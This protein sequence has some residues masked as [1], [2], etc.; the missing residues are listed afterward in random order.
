MNAVQPSVG[1]V[2]LRTL[3]GFK[4]Y[5]RGD[6]ENRFV[7]ALCEISL[8]VEHAASTLLCFDGEFPTI[9]EMREAALNLRPKFEAKADQKKEWEAKYGKPDPA[10]SRRISGA[11]GANHVQE[12]RAILWQSIRDA[13][14]YTETQMGRL[15]LS[16]IEDKDERINAFKFWKKAAVNNQRNHPAELAAFREELDRS[17]WDELMAYDW[18]RGDWPPSAL[19]PVV[20]APG[21]ILANP[22]TQS[23]IDRELERAGRG[24][25]DGE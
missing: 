11:A 8:S 15:D 18:A 19:G 25:G 23:D 24:P 17:S 2:L 1:K 7:D 21:A 5:P 14:F 3:S 6:G 9:R 22:I 16:G 10:F 4:G 12:R 20:V 13:V